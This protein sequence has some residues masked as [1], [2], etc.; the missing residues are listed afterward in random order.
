M[1]EQHNINADISA[2]E[3]L[4]SELAGCDTVHVRIL[5][6]GNKTMHKVKKL[7][8][9]ECHTPLSEPFRIK[10]YFDTSSIFI[11]VIYV[12]GFTLD[13]G[14]LQCLITQ[15]LFLNFHNMSM[16]MSL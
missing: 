5:C 8:N 2:T 12:K 4:H 6:F 1:Q 16:T 14:I 10:K 13:F 9:F 11:H 15:C 3:Y 7:N